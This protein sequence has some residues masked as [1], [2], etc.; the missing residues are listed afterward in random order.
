VLERQQR[1]IVENPDMKLRVLSI[2]SGGAHARHI[3]ERMAA[4]E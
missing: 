4:N 3:L 1:S 2:D